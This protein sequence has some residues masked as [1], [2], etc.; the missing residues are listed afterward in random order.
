MQLFDDYLRESGG[1]T[2]SVGGAQKYGETFSVQI[3]DAKGGASIA[4]NQETRGIFIE[5]NGDPILLWNETSF[6]VREDAGTATVTIKRL[7]DIPCDASQNTCFENTN[8]RHGV[9][10]G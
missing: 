1:V 9:V 6:K 3:Y 8:C 7:Y 5:E 4:G 2:H 10:V